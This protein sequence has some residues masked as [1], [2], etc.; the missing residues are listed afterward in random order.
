MKKV[1]KFIKL[2]LCSIMVITLIPKNVFAQTYLSD[3][4]K[5]ESFT[6]YE[7]IM[8][9]INKEKRN[10][11]SNDLQELHDAEQELRDLKNHIYNMKEKSIEELKAY[12]YT[13]EQIFNIKNYDG[14]N[15]MTAKASSVITRN[16]ASFT[17][18]SYNSTTKRT[19]AKIK[20]TY[21][22][23]GVPTP[24]LD[25]AIYVGLHDGG[26]WFDSGNGT[27]SVKYRSYYN[28]SMHY[29]TLSFNGKAGSFSTG[30]RLFTFDLHK[31]YDNYAYYVNSMTLTFNAGRS[32]NI[33][34]V[35]C[36]NGFTRRKAKISAGIGISSSGLSISFTGGL[37][38]S[39]IHWS[40]FQNK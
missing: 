29:K 6:E 27:L 31:T 3:E 15:E 4:N 34:K 10:I 1:I 19:T 21:T 33:S 37:L 5:C 11:N 13:D 40:A 8:S 32:G 23:N 36:V 30:S 39:T 25:A 20:C 26:N 17:S 22:I 12:N 24:N 18:K 16:S 9:Y 28:D 38:T 7:L 35:Q 2:I 14:S